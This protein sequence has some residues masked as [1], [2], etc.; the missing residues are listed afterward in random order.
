MAQPEISFSTPEEQLQYSLKVLTQ[1]GFTPLQIERIRNEVGLG[2]NK[3]PY[4]K[5][6]TGWRR[7]MVQEL[8]AARM[9]NRQIAEALNLSKETV[10]GDR[11]H[12]REIWTQQI[13][14]SQDTWRAQ[15]LREQAELKDMAVQGFHAS[16]KR[17]TITTN[18]ETGNNVVKV[19]ETAGESSFLTVAK[20]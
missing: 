8:L 16:K 12:N 10:N 14:K 15:L 2:K 7:F 19:E 11:K 20:G 9:S 6:S 3:I 13:L 4:D 1:A 18:E 5:E 17:R